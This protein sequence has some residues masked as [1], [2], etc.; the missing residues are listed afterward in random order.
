MAKP[1]HIQPISPSL[2]PASAPTAGLLRRLGALLYDALV[3]T[4]L[5]IIA[6][7]IGMGIA[8]LLL[9][10]GMASVPAGEDTVWL[11][12]RHSLSLIYTLW[13]AFVVCGFYTW[14]W[15]RAGQTVGM[16]AWRL[17]IQNEDGSQ[18]RV[19]QALIRLATAAFGLGN[20]MCLFNRK[21][22][23]AFQDIWAE[24]EVIVL[25]KQENLAMLNK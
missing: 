9:I 7:F 14:F 25:S 21:H 11:L 16:R 6:G 18:L 20:L 22:P 17:R 8:K 4:S 1:K 15:T 19:T 2:N 13:L 12:T 3:V 5:L 23:R 10:T 24:C